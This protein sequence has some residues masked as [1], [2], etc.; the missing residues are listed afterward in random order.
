MSYLYRI[1][2]SSSEKVPT[3]QYGSKDTFSSLTTEITVEKPLTDKKL[4]KYQDNLARLTRE[5]VEKESELIRGDKQTGTIPP[6]HRL[7]DINGKPCPH[8][9]NIITPVTPPIPFIIEH[10]LQGTWLDGCFKNLIDEG[11]L[12]PSDETPDTPNIGSVKVLFETAEKW[13]AEHC[14]LGE[15]DFISHSRKI[16]NK[17]HWF[18]GELDSEGLYKGKQAIFDFKK[19]KKIP[20]GLRDKY[21]MQMAA[22]SMGDGVIKPKYLVICSPYNPPIVTD[23]VKKYRDMFLKARTDYKNNFNV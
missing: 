21:F 7:T 16:V 23:E 4:A 3:V 12:S 17:K 2:Q 1:T 11:V 19:T 13:V 14:K 5:A 10:G 20:K 22:Y 6:H 9:T 15:V 8:V 18:C